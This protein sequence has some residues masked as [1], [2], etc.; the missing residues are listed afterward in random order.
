M[1]EGA[2]AGL[3]FTDDL[4]TRPPV[5]GGDAVTTLAHFAIITY[6]V[7]ADRVRPHFHPR[8][9]LDCYPGPRGEPLV[10]VSMVPFEDRDFR[11]IAIPRPDATIASF[12]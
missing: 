9:D 8:F 7:A 12:S 2:F 10:W 4:L 3:S 1:A 5:S 6:A 11:F